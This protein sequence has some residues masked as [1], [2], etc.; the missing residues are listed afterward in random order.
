MHV[1]IEL[2][3]ESEATIVVP[4]SEDGVE[5]LDWAGET[6]E[7]T[8]QFWSEAAS[9]NVLFLSSVDSRGKVLHRVQVR[10]SGSDGKIRMIDRSK[11]VRPAC[12]PAPKTEKSSIPSPG[13]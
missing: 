1:K 8:P 9:P 13:K 3:G 2:P 10:V 4:A 7:I 12:D 6:I 11:K 5:D